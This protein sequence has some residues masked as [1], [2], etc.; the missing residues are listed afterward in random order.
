M[1]A[2][3]SLLHSFTMCCLCISFTDLCLC[4][5]D[6]KSMISAGLATITSCNYELMKNAIIGKQNLNV[7]C[8]GH[9]GGSI[10]LFLASEI[11]GY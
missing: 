6:V 3:G 7:L 9:G 10:P 11:Q 5:A 8:I 4:F 2:S 1:H